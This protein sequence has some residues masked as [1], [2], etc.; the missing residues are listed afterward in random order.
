MSNFNSPPVGNELANRTSGL[1]IASLICGFFGVPI[2]PVA[3]AALICGIIALTKMSSDSTLKGKGM[4]I[5]GTILGGIGLLV[6]P[7]LL[8]GTILPALG[9]ARSTARQM[10]DSTQVRGIAMALTLYAENNNDQFPEPG[11]DWQ[12][13]LLA[14]GSVTPELL[15]TPID[16]GENAAGVPSYL[17]YTPSSTDNPQTTVLVIT[18]PA[19]ISRGM[20]NVGYLDGHVEAKKKEELERIAADMAARPAPAPKKKIKP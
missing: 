10:K 14:T 8:M 6:T 15:I 19:V 5:A 11:A 17:Y 2:F 7:C 1:A 16:G 12:Q 18:N 9:K 13:R 3:L 4:A 20:G